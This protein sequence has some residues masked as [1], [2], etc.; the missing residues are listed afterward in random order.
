MSGVVLWAMDEPRVDVLRLLSAYHA[1][2][3]PAYST[4]FWFARASGPSPNHWVRVG[5]HGVRGKAG[6]PGCAGPFNYPTSPS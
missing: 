2:M 3:F 5:Q 1:P 4:P 6:G